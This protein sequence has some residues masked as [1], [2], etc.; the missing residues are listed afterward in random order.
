MVKQAQAKQ[1][2]LTI[3]LTGTR[4]ILLHNGRL[5]NPM[6]FYTR[7]LKDLTA[8]RNKTDEDHLAISLAEARG[9]AYETPDNLLAY[10]TANVWRSILDAS[11]T[12]KLGKLVER[13]LRYNPLDI[14]PLLADGQAVDVDEYLKDPAHIFYRSVRNQR[15]RVMRSRPIVESWT[16]DHR[17][18]LDLKVLD[19]DRL[20]PVLE[21]AGAMV[22]LGDWRPTYGT[23]TVEVLACE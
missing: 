17:F 15:N 9:G 13:G 23:F 4:P 18:Q 1:A 12:F 7:R 21:C 2:Q 11:R 10:P 8:K 14:Q 3:R 6:D 16:T 5:A 22:G 20:A 19:Q